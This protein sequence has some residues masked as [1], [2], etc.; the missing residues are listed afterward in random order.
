MILRPRIARGGATPQRPATGPAV[1][2]PPTA[3]VP[4]DYAASFELRGI[5]GNVAEDVINVSADGVFVATAIGYGFEED[6]GQPLEVSA[7]APPKPPGDV[8]LGDFPLDAF[9]TG[10]RVNPRFESLVFATPP[11]GGPV[12]PPRGPRRFSTDPVSIGQVFQRVKPPGGLSFL[13]SIVDSGS[14]RELQD[15]PSLNLASLGKSTGERP[16]RRL[17]QPLSFAPRSTIRL[18]V[19]ERSVGVTGTLFIVLYGYK[20]TAAACPEPVVRAM[21]AALTRSRPGAILPAEASVPFDSVA[22]I[23]LTGRTGNIVDEE[24]HLSVDG[25]FVATALGYGLATESADIPLNLDPALNT[26]DLNTI[27]LRSLPAD[28][29][30]VGFRIRPDLLRLAFLGG[31]LNP[32]FPADL[33]GTLFESLNRPEDVAFRYTIRD[34]GMGRDFQNQAINNVAGLGIADGHRP[35]KTFARPM[36]FM[37]RSTIRITAREHFGQG[38]LQFVFQGYKLLP[39]ALVGGLP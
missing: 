27:P 39:S 12:A 9:I 37:P 36:V 31:G 4:Y 16:F 17:S 14:G 21:Q 7:P 24:V 29:L 35:F 18:Q 19:I 28:A 34:G 30:A 13:F 11:I 8:T 38:T 22:S 32:S 26:V 25:A 15:R 20:R 33:A 6:R 23:S 1:A 5:P 3:V 2:T 10:L